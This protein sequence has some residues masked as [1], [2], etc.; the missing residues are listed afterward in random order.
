MQHT[1]WHM[2]SCCPSQHELPMRLSMRTVAERLL[3]SAIGG[4]RAVLLSLKQAF[5]NWAN[6]EHA[7]GWTWDSALPMCA[8]WH[9]V[10][11]SPDGHVTGLNLST[12]APT[13]PIISPIQYGY[14]DS[15]VHGSRAAQLQGEAVLL[16]QSPDSPVVRKAKGTGDSRLQSGAGLH[17]EGLPG[18]GAGVRACLIGI[19]A[20][21]VRMEAHDGSH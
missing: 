2:L 6:V 20:A 7:E 1:L 19:I 16:S 11:C 4:D 5:W 10:T 8:S 14:D 3:S 9:G 17:S 12:T 13:V 18:Y 21:D 15:I